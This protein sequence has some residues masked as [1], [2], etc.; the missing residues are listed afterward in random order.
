[1]FAVSVA[2]PYVFAHAAELTDS[3]M[4]VTVSGQAGFSGLY[5]ETNV[6]AC[7]AVKTV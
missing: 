5:C 2:A 3:R 4:S 1:M 6:P 7:I